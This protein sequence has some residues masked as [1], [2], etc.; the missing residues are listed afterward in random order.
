MKLPRSISSSVDLV[1]RAAVGKDWSLYAT[2]IEHWGEIVGQ[3]YAKSTEPAKINFPKGK[4]AGQSW[5]GRDQSGGTLTI[6][7]PQGLTMEFGFLTDQIRERINRFFGYEAI[8][9]IQFA[10]YYAEKEPEAAPA[11]QK[12]LSTAEIDNLQDSLKDIENKELREALESLGESV[13]KEHKR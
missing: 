4:K 13:L 11:P 12:E 6:K 3:E 8:D 5:G 9:K 7:L 2:L 10:P 1:A